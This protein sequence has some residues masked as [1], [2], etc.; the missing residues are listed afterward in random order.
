M[1]IANPILDEHGP[2]ELPTTR[3]LLPICR[4]D[5]IS[6][7]RRPQVMKMFALA[8]VRELPS[9]DGLDMFRLAGDDGAETSRQVDLDAIRRCRCAVLGEEAIK[10]RAQLVCS[11]CFEN[12]QY[13]AAGCFPSPYS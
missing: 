11:L 1:E 8:I 12:R 9:Q 10:E 6:Q 4:E 5:T 3:P 2:D 13:K 7:E